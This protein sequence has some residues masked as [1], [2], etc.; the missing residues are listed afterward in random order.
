MDVLPSAPIVVTSLGQFALT[1][2]GVGVRFSRKAPK[3]PLELLKLLIALGGREVSEAFACDVL[4]PDADGDQA[5]QALGTTL[6]RL[7]RLIGDGRAV[8]RHGGRLALDPSVCW[9]DAWALEAM[10]DRAEVSLATGTANDVAARWADRAIALYQ[11]DFLPGDD[12]P[13]AFEARMRLHERLVAVLDWLLGACTGA[14]S[15]WRDVGRWRT[16]LARVDP[17]GAASGRDMAVRA[18]S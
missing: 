12:A 16:A 2:H 14:A 9:V 4:W 15:P 17:L 5:V 8:Q 10:L 6:H 13:W 18:L 3:K 11:G 7:R 1:I